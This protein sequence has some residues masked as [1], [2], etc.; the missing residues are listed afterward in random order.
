MLILTRKAGKAL[1]IGDEI[2]VAVIEIKGSQVR[3]GIDAPQGI[4][5]HGTEI[6]GQVASGRR[7]VGR[8][9]A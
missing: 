8:S 5:R 1:R 4:R 7:P 3:P 6:G 2:T 9:G